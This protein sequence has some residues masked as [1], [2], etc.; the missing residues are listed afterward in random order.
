[1][2]KF[3]L[4]TVQ[5]IFQ[6][7]VSKRTPLENGADTTKMRPIRFDVVLSDISVIDQIFM[8]AFFMKGDLL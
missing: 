7:I 6:R 5:N 1:M 4:R 8:D 3:C 2:G